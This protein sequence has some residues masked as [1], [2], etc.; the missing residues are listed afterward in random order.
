MKHSSH[1][2]N[3][4][5]AASFTTDQQDLSDAPPIN[6]YAFWNASGLICSL[7]HLS[8]QKVLSVEITNPII[9]GETV[10]HVPVPFL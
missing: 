7:L 8:E 1:T 4:Y 2:R 5:P 6:N 9:L 3:Y 10:S